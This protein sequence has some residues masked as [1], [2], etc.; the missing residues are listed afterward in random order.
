MPI[1]STSE[2]RQAVRQV[3]DLLQEIQDFAGQEANEAARLRF[4]RGFLRTASDHRKRLSFVSDA[5]LQSNI[6][7]SIMLWD[8]Y[9]WVLVRTD[10]AG[11]ARDMVIKA[12]LTLGGGIAEAILTDYLKRH[13]GKRRRFT[14]RTMRLAELGVISEALRAELD[15]L[16][17]MRNRQHLYDVPDWEYDFYEYADYARAARTLGNLIRALSAAGPLGH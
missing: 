1:E 9:R 17:D 2:L 5:T 15:W 16:W 12:A 3:G 11:T 14:S 7:Y 8:V 4:P 10:L 13:M 6:A